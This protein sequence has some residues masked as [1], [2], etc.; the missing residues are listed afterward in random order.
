MISLVRV[1]RKFQQLI[2]N[3]EES[4]L[5]TVQIE[6]STAESLVGQLFSLGQEISQEEKRKLLIFL[7]SSNQHNRF[8]L[9]CKDKEPDVLFVGDFMVQLMQQYEVKV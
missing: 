2:A 3:W 4:A 1:G 6:C 7:S 8:V 5:G 9:D